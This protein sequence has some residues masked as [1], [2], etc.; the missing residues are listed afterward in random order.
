MAHE[1][2]CLM[3]KRFCFDTKPMVELISPPRKMNIKIRTKQ[4]KKK[5]KKKKA[6]QNKKQILAKTVRATSVLVSVSLIF[7]W[8]SMTQRLIET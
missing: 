1:D 6:N 8:G 2:K 4:T 7:V 5:R 3:V